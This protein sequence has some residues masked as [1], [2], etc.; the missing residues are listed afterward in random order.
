MAIPQRNADPRNICVADRTF[1]I[2]ASIWGKRSL[3]QSDRAACLFVE[4]LLE[5]RNAGRYRLHEYVVMPDHFHALVTVGP[6]ITIE[7]A[8][9]FIKGAFAFRAGRAFGWHAPI[10]Q[11]G[12]SEV[13]VLDAEAFLNFR[14][15]IWGNPVRARL[16][17]RV[18]DYEFSSA[19][20][21]EKLDLPPQRLKAL[22]PQPRFGTPEGVP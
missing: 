16:V 20:A 8:V 7:R 6:G 18:E 2:T 3:L 12:F 9:Q 17:Q 22:I 11:K 14:K 4:N 1:F 21:R 5:H 10:W 19:S 15:Y 13:R